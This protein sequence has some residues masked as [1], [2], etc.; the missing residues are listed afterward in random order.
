[1]RHFQIARLKDLVIMS[2]H[3]ESEDVIEVNGA[4]EN[5]LQDQQD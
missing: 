2:K 4:I 5:Q 3:I 1:M